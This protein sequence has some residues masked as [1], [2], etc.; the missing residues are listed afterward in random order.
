MKSWSRSNALDVAVG[1]DEVDVVRIDAVGDPGDLHAG[2]GDSERASGLCAGDIRVGL[3][4]RESFGIEL[5]GAVLAAGTGD[6]VRGQGRARGRA[7]RGGPASGSRRSAPDGDVGNH[8]CHRRVRLEPCQFA[9]GDGGR[10]RVDQLIALDV[11]GLCPAE[12]ADQGR[13]LSGD[14]PGAHCRVAATDRSGRG[15][16]LHHD[17]HR[18]WRAGGHRRLRGRRRDHALGADHDHRQRSGDHTSDDPAPGVH[19][20]PVAYPTYSHACHLVI[21]RPTETR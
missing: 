12:L 15:L 16:A 1:P 13:L 14:R 19:Q 3:R 8:L 21:G 10:Q 2:A 4:Q 20:L 7:G 6:H 9:L 11:G 5:D 17:D 18:L